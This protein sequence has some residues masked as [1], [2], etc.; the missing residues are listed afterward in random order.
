MDND[1]ENAKQVF[2][3]AIQFAAGPERQQFLREKC[4]DDSKLRERV[5]KLIQAHEASDYLLGK[6]PDGA[7]AEVS[8]TADYADPS[9]A[10]LGEQVGPYRLREIIG[11]G[12]MGTVYVAEQE[13]PIRRKVALKVI[14]RGMDSKAIVARFEAERQAIA[15]MDHP[16]IARVLDAGTTP[17]G[18]PY[19]VMELVQGA[20][21]TT[22]CDQRRLS[23][24][25]RLRLFKGVCQAIKHAHQKGIIHRDIKPSNILVTEQDGEAAAKVIDFGVAKALGQRLTDQTVYTNFQAVIGTP[26]Y[27]SPEQAALSNVDVDT[28]SDVYSLGVLLY[29]LLTG[30]TP[31]CRDSLKKA[32]QEEVLRMIREQEPPKPSTRISSL[33]EGAGRISNGRSVDAASLSRIVRGELDWIVMKALEKDRARRYETTT[34]LADDIEN[35]LMGNAVQAGP[36]STWYHLRKTVRRHYQ[37]VSLLLAA[38][39]VLL[40]FASVLTWK[41]LELTRA[42]ADVARAEAEATSLNEFFIGDLLGQADPDLNPYQEQTTVVALLDRAAERIERTN[43]FQQQPRVEAAIRL[44]IGRTYLALGQW[45]SAKMHLRRAHLLRREALGDDSPL[46]LAVLESLVDVYTEAEDY[47]EALAAADELQESWTSMLGGDA[48]RTIAAKIARTRI[49]MMQGDYDAAEVLAEENLLAVE[50]PSFNDVETRIQA[51]RTLADV[52]SVQFKDFERALQMYDRNIS[53]LRREGKPEHSR[54]ILVNRIRKIEHLITLGRVKESEHIAREVLRIRMDAL[55]DNHPD[56]ISTRAILANT[57]LVQG[58]LR[59]AHRLS[60]TAYEQ[61]TASLGDNH[62]LAWLSRRVL[63]MTLNASAMVSANRDELLEEAEQLGK[64]NLDVTAIRGWS[65]LDSNVHQSRTDYAVTLGMRGILATSSDGSRSEARLLEEAF[66]RLRTIYEE[67]LEVRG[68]KNSLTIQAGA[69]LADIWLAHDAKSHSLEPL[70][71]T[72]RASTANLV[73][74]LPFRANLDQAKGKLALNGGRFDEADTLFQQYFE[75]TRDS[76]VAS[77]FDHISAAMNLIQLRLAQYKVSVLDSIPLEAERAYEVELYR[78][79]ATPLLLLTTGNR[80]KSSLFNLKQDK[81]RLLLTPTSNGSLTPRVIALGS[82]SKGEFQLQVRECELTRTETIPGE[83]NDLSKGRAFHGGPLLVIN[84]SMKAGR[85]YR[86]QVEGD[87]FPA[88]LLV[89]DSEGRILAWPALD[90]DHEKVELSPDA[91]GDFSVL[92][93]PMEASANGECRLSVSEFT[94]RTGIE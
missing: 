72:L 51:R 74:G 31:F 78:E 9:D 57:L 13:T 76:P 37:A 35:Y 59:E 67:S 69:Q 92:V 52:V 16:N 30:S 47:E 36:P 39:I 54:E 93:F 32:G 58:K 14:K 5:L 11:E 80:T 15:L 68:P 40:A 53:D 2:L 91:D 4:G 28:R 73:R 23:I 8:V 6:T 12:G 55:P 44:V 77:K 63:V 49:L 18:S 24:R 89:E 75:F 33:G 65:P 1:A 45:N 27:M 20:E 61:A 66:D 21:I 29:E 85:W 88:S 3:D 43:A 46:T 25:E 42:L 70:I 41:N 94:P 87:D 82:T 38:I 83:L 90:D 19:F 62:Y 7:K 86:M 50:R 64:Q 34:Q 81:S 79:D 84:V 71:D 10:R 56:T 17:G 60:R 22:Y 26:L 48:P